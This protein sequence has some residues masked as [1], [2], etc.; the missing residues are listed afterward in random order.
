MW[1]FCAVING[2]PRPENI[3]AQVIAGARS[4]WL[5][6]GWSQEVC[7]LSVLRDVVIVCCP[8]CRTGGLRKAVLERHWW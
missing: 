2:R 1:R 7:F 5:F 4:E 6:E 3:C 8:S